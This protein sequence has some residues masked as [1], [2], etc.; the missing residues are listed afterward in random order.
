MRQSAIHKFNLIF[1]AP[2][3]ILKVAS[4]LATVLLLDFV[5]LIAVLRRSRCGCWAA[6]LY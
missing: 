4:L 6:T 5:F 2:L 1:S 3:P